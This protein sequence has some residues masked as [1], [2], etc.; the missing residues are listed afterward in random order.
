MT[1]AA[2]SSDI[3]MVRLHHQCFSQRPFS[4]TEPRKY[5][6]PPH[7]ATPRAL[8]LARGTRIEDYSQKQP[9][10]CV[11]TR[12]ALRR[13]LP[14]RERQQLRRPAVLQRRRGGALKRRSLNHLAKPS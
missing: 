12:S 11:R 6:L 2:A 1:W 3:V 9:P 5:L 13:P 14:T 7:D 10:P 4:I 8:T